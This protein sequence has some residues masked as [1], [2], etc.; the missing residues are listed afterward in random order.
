MQVANVTRRAV[1]T[2][3]GLG[4]LLPTLAAQ[5]AF[6]NPKAHIPPRAHRVRMSGGEATAPLPLPATPVRRSEHHRKPAPP[7]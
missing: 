2:L 1:M 4:I 7:D 6:F 5:A 3:A